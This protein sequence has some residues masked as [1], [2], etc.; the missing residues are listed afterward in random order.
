M[1]SASAL[2]R[3]LAF[4]AVLFGAASACTTLVA[5]KSATIDGSVMCV[6]SNDGD[7]DTAGN[8]DFVP[9]ADWPANATTYGGIPQVPSTYAYF[10]KEGGYAST[11]EHQVSLAESTCN[12]IFAG[13]APGL[14][15]IVDLSLLGL[16]RA[17]TARAAIQVMGGLAEKHGYND[18][19]ESL[20]VTDPHEAWVFQIL[21]DDTGASA[22][23]VGQRLPD[24]H[25]GVVANAFTVRAVD[26]A[27]QDAGGSSNLSFLTSANMRA[28]ALKHG[29][30][31][32][33]EP[34][35]FTRIYSGP[36]YGE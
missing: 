5:G 15:N 12:G 9:A 17:T 33:G 35:D 25:V 6:H 24:H 30:W 26:F 28:V 2:G 20:F 27:A 22:I 7:G 23:W 10:T 34:F 13:R 8:L 29:R 1:R 4:V 18:A 31:K 19:G 36:E 16:Q 14:L 3:R 21:P 32:A 11:N